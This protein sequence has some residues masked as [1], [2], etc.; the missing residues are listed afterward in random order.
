MLITAAEQKMEGGAEEGGSARAARG[1]FVV[2]KRDGRVAKASGRESRG[3]G[4]DSRRRQLFSCLLQA[5]EQG[6]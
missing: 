4:I 6:C 1:L 5:L 2:A 3:P